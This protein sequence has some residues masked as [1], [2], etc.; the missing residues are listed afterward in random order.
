M[1]RSFGKHD[2]RVRDALD[3][4]LFSEL[5]EELRDRILAEAFFLDVPAGTV[6]Y[7]EYEPARIG[8]VVTGLLRAYLSSKEG[9]Q[10][11]V[12]YAGPGAMLGMPALVGGP[13]PVRVQAL[14]DSTGLI[15]GPNLLEELSKLEPGFGW[16]VAEEV[17]ANYCDLMIILGENVF[18]SVEVRTAR[19]L[20]ALA[21]PAEAVPAVT[22]SQRELAEAVGSVR[23]VV[24]RILHKFQKEGL[25]GLEPERI[26][27]RNPAGLKALA[28]DS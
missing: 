6:I 14:K 19:H 21:S 22:M 1:D 2:Q 24:S 17:G 16:K 5:P 4:N 20:L 18:D 27:L 12:K 28:R 26:L 8:I 9:R 13:L 11:T 10:I 3:K 25:V 23:E 7:R 15:F